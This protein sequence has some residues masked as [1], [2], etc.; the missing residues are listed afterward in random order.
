MSPTLRHCETPCPHNAHN[1]ARGAALIQYVLDD[2]F[3]TE[4]H[5]CHMAALKTA[6]AAL[7]S[8]GAAAQS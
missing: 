8:M 6:V 3:A 7:K 2:D 4:E 1:G 5:Y